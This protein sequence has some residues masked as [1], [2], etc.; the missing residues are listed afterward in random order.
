MGETPTLPFPG[1]QGNELWKLRQ[2]C[3][4]R[5]KRPVT[6]RR[7]EE[8]GIECDRV[9]EVEQGSTAVPHRE[10]VN[11][12]SKLAV[13]TDPVA[14]HTDNDPAGQARYYRILRSTDDSPEGLLDLVDGFLHPR[15]SPPAAP[16]WHVEQDERQ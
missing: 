3:H 10:P 13:W 15:Q 16:E 4:Q 5:G 6:S 1:S 11:C 14:K 12:D 7:I 8:I 9:F 2:L